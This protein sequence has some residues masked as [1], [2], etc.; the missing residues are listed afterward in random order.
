MKKLKEIL[1][2]VPI[3]GILGSTNVE[4]PQISIDSRKI[5]KGG[6]YVAIKGVQ[7][8]GHHLV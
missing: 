2:K 7:V 5:E 6:I 8:D 3:E 1:Y 4:V